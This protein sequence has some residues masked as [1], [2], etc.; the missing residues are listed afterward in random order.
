MCS[1]LRGT[2]AAARKPYNN[3][4]EKGKALSSHERRDCPRAKLVSFKIEVFLIQIEG[5]LAAEFNEAWVAAVVTADR[6]LTLAR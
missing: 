3:E 4:Y 5:I 6:P 1:W 2:C